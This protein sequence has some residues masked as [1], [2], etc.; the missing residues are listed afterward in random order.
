MALLVGLHAQD[1]HADLLPLLHH[2]LGVGDAGMAQLRDVDEPFEPAQVDEGAEI[3]HRAHRALQDRAHFQLLAQLL[4]GLRPFLLEERAAREDG[5]ATAELH[6][7]ELEL[8]ADVLREILVEPD[9]DLR[10]RAES[11]QP[12]EIDLQP[13]LVLR[14]DRAFDGDLALQRLLQRL[15]AGTLRH[16]A[17]E[18]H[19]AVAEGEDVRLDGL[20]RVHHHLAGIVAKLAQVDDG[21]ALAA[22]IEVG[23]L[24]ADV[25]HLGGDL[26]AEAQPLAFLAR[27]LALAE[28]RPE[29]RRFIW[30]GP[31]ED[32]LRRGPRRL[33]LRRL[34]GRFLRRRLAARGGSRRLVLDRMLRAP[35]SA[36]GRQ[37]PLLDRMLRP[38]AS[39]RRRQSP[40]LDR[41]LRP[42][43][44]ARRRQSPLLR[45]LAESR[46][47][48]HH[49]HLPLVLAL[50]TR[51]PGGQGPRSAV[52]R[53]QLH[54]SDDLCEA[55][56]RGPLP[57]LGR[58][59]RGLRLLRL[60]W[61]FGLV[62][63]VGERGQL[64]LVRHLAFDLR[65]KARLI[66][67]RA[68]GKAAPAR[69][70]R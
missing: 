30:R 20:A 32:R 66:P 39:A 59:G 52:L 24:G 10:G 5:I 56:R 27:L 11:A 53:V 23:D 60:G 7:P 22:Q 19:R 34:C 14:G 68:S 65:G 15:P 61:P 63:D 8:L 44:S 28:E 13:A 58:R 25:R 51:R 64:V 26:L 3:A 43:A 36:R 37:S 18:H 38:A 49:R 2:V 12:A 21:L 17:G 70:R 1:L 6:H 46:F 35:A 9:V 16:A 62:H 54:R 48:D 57:G 41:M 50:R 42:A 47:A 29:I 33:A 55:R 45:G 4:G 40:L 31:R 67:H 69:D